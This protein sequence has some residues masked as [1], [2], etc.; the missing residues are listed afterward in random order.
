MR[1]L[2]EVRTT[3]EKLYVKY[4]VEEQF[5]DKVYGGI[6]KSEEMIVPWLVGRGV[7]KPV[8]EEL[9]VSISL[10]IKS[11]GERQEEVEEL[12]PEVSKAWT[13]F[14]SDDEGLY[15][16]AR[17]VKASLK[18]AANILYRTPAYKRQLLG[19]RQVINHGVFVHPDKIRLMKDGEVVKRPDGWDESPIHVMGPRG[20]RTALKRQDY[21]RNAT[22]IYQIWVT[23]GLLSEH[24]LK[25]MLT[26]N[27][28]QGRGASRSQGAGTFDVKRFQKLTD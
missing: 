20:E 13:G 14:L 4:E 11:K 7:P 8:A 1:T 19:Y 28:E 27:Q 22:I 21:V 24:L 12:E 3:S 2:K 6:P 16:E 17:Q 9:A 18:E 15:V 10:G 25:T 23:G 5:R 26:L